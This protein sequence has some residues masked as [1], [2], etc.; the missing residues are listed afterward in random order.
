MQ[1]EDLTFDTDAKTKNPAY[2]IAHQAHKSQDFIFTSL[3]KITI[4]RITPWTI[5]LTK[6]K[7]DGEKMRETR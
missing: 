2:F 1:F 7:T 5:E 4:C 3:E 6:K